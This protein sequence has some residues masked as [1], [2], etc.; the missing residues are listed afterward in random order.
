M[1]KLIKLFIA[2]VIMLPVVVLADA[3]KPNIYYNKNVKVGE[4]VDEYII[5]SNMEPGKI[6][7]LNYDTNYL[8]FIEGSAQIVFEGV[9]LIKNKNASIEVSNGKIVFNVASLPTETYQDVID[10]DLAVDST[11]PS[12][13]VSFK[14][15]LR[16]EKN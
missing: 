4:R 6:F 15:F 7:E 1:K 10:G 16:Y 5:L 11:E 13:Y 12:I 9:E 3:Y 8:E 14:A 2:I